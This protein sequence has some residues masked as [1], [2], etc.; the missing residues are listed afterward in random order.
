MRPVFVLIASLLCFNLDAG[1]GKKDAVAIQGTWKMIRGELDG[2]PLTPD[3][4]ADGKV[5]IGPDIFTISSKGKRAETWRYV[6][7]PTKKPRAI[8]FFE[9]KSKDAAPGIYALEGDQLKV[10]WRL[11]EDTKSIER[12]TE[13]KSAAGSAVVLIVLQRQKK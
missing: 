10:C 5:V 7:D 6:L 2:K 4:I 1:E 13:F 9:A 12:P 3:E 8:D 11:G